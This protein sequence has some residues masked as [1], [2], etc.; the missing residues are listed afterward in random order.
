MN[1]KKIYRFKNTI[2]LKDL[3]VIFARRK[4]FF[5]GFFLF[6]LIVGL[7]F[8]FIRT[9]VYQSSSILKL[10]GI[11]Y[12]ENLYKYFP[13]EAQ[14]L[15]IFAP[16]LDVKEMES[17]ILTDMTRKMHEDTLLDDIADKLEFDVSSEELDQAIYALVDSGNRIVRINVTY[18]SAEGSYQINDTLID[19]YLENDRNSKSDL[20]EYLISEIDDII[21]SMEKQFKD[22]ENQNGDVDDASGEID[23]ISSLIVDLNKIKYNLENNKTTYINNI[24]ILEEPVIPVKAVGMDNLRSILITIF[25]AAAAGLIAVYIPN[26]FVPFKK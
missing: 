8:T 1:K 2:K 11:Y 20:I 18:G 16:G 19:T 12:D 14:L 21:T 24:E 17:A 26:I 4:W 25:A 22:I 5:I 23:S 6:V 13:E 9:P 15:G 3:A 7:L 10:K